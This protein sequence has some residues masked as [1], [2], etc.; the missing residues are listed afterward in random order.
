MCVLYFLISR[1]NGHTVHRGGDPCFGVLKVVRF[2]LNKNETRLTTL[3][4]FHD[5][6]IK[7]GSNSEA[8][9]LSTGLPYRTFSASIDDDTFQ[10]Y[11]RFHRL[12]SRERPH[13]VGTK[14]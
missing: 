1:M 3:K 7:I 4:R 9:G 11:F 5:E 12:D 13:K 10:R 6:Q 14:F 8:L 2:R